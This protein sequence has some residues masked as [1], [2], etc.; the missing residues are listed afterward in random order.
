MRLPVEILNRI[1]SF[2]VSDLST[3]TTCSKDPLLFP[4]VERHL[5]YHVHVHFDGRTDNLG[6]FGPDDLSNRISENPRIVHYVRILH[7]EFNSISTQTKV[8][9]EFATTLRMFSLLESIWLTGTDVFFQFPDAFRA[10]FEDRLGQPTIKELRLDGRTTIPVS[11]LN[12]VK[13]L[14]DLFLSGSFDVTGRSSS[15]LPQ[16]KSLSMNLTSNSFPAGFA[17]ID[18]HTNTVQSLRLSNLGPLFQLRCLQAQT[19]NILDI[20]LHKSQCK[21]PDLFRWS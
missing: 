16:L 5:Y 11:W 4:I 6:T 7:L 13:N 8:L 19:L 17:W 3:L 14:E 12:R 21:S 15:T 10:A 18:L 20:C 9:L 1:F 2:L